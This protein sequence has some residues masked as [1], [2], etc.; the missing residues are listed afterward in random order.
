MTRKIAKYGSVQKSLPFS[1]SKRKQCATSTTKRFS[2]SQHSRYQVLFLLVT[3]ILGLPEM[4][5][6]HLMNNKRYV[7]I[8]DKAQQAELW[9]IETGKCVHKFKEPFN[10][11]KE[12]LSSKY[13]Q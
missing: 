10:S 2:Q 9:E 11:A 8:G 4:S 12:L 7:L 3:L 5:E 6:Y 1:A 13:D